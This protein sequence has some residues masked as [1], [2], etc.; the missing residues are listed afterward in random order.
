MARPRNFDE[1]EVLDRALDV[2]WKKGYHATSYEDLVSGMG[3]N[4]A[5]MYNTYGDKHQLLVKSLKRYQAKN[6][7]RLRQL[8]DSGKSIQETFRALFYE[9][10]QQNCDDPQRR[11]CMVV[12]VTT[13]LGG[14]DPE[15]SDIVRQNQ[16]Q[17]EEAFA[18]L[19]SQ[20]KERGEISSHL[21]PE[22]LARFIY[23]TYN[24]LQVLAKSN[25]PRE[26]LEDVVEV[27]LTVLT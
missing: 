7:A 22:A 5:S 9:S 6:I 8:F 3:I 24:G 27:S 4:R 1:N 2:F 10:I 13:E 25:P 16:R 14:W 20:A 21:R 26:A 15:I 11:G 19:I 17:L 18:S 12:N 23:N